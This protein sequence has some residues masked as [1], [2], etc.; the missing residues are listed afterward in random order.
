MVVGGLYAEFLAAPLDAWRERN[1][2]NI[3]PHELPLIVQ[4]FLVFFISEF[5]WYWIHR[6]E[7]RF[8]FVWRLSGHGAHHSFKRLGALNAGLNHP[9]ELFFLAIPPAIVEFVFGSG[10][11]SAGAAI[12]TVTQA[13][14]AHTN[15]RMNTKVIGWLFTTNRYHI[16]HHSAVLEESNTNYGCAAI[17]WDR[18]FG[19]FVDSDIV[20]AGTGPTEPTLWQKFVM[21]VKEPTDT[22]IAP[23]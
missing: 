6:L 20:D 10:I 9:L 17:L 15:L 22:A 23:G 2:L 12:L 7:H 5:F 3:W 14:I 4:L 1:G 16:R 13:S 8:Y 11:A 21:P 18:V 19:T